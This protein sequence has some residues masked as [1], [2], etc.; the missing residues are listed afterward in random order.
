VLL[1]TVVLGLSALLLSGCLPP[2]LQ[3]ASWTVTGVS[4][5]F[6]G[7]SVGDHVLSLA[8]EKDCATWRVLQGNRI[9]VDHDR[10]YDNGWDAVAST[11]KVP[12]LGAGDDPQDFAMDGPV[13]IAAATEEFIL[14]DASDDVE[15]DVEFAE[16]TADQRS[17]PPDSLSKD[18]VM[19]AMAETAEG[20]AP[21][22]GPSESLTPT[23][24][25]LEKISA[26]AEAGQTPGQTP[27]RSAAYRGGNDNGI[28]L[29]IGSF[30]SNQRALKLQARHTGLNTAIMQ[31][32]ISGKSLYRVLAGP[33]DKSNLATARR[34]LVKG[35]VRHSW[36]MRLCKATLTAP[37]CVTAVQQ[38]A[39]PN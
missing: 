37:P 31:A 25:Q 8:A 39:L 23:D 3:V 38:A 18:A 6:S 9:C 16:N 32:R 36:A 34:R 13:Q 24:A 2:V 7:K 21:A 26:T 5:V 20:V 22:S 35:G 27:V 4:Y 10:V 14:L 28:Y 17:L 1:R 12:T 19:I 30:R 15:S 29:V 33:L 11:F